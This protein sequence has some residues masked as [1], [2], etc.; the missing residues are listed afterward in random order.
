MEVLLHSGV[1]DAVFSNNPRNAL[2]LCVQR[3][4]TPSPHP[5]HPSQS[6]AAFTVI[7]MCSSLDSI[8]TRAHR[9]GILHS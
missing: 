7:Q 2:S 5:L 3:Q 8:L 1:S 6:R 9:I 4:K